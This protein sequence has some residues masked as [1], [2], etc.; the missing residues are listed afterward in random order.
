MGFIM[1]H[2]LWLKT[3][4]MMLLHKE[5]YYYSTRLPNTAQYIVNVYRNTYFYI[6]R[7]IKKNT[8]E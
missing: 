5:N 3:E 7:Q 8:K 2:R 4:N 1:K 6:N